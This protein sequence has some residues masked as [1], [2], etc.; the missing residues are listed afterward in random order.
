LLEDAAANSRGQK[1]LRIS[2]KNCESRSKKRR[3]GEKKK[4]GESS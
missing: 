1:S 4:R 3:S 2:R